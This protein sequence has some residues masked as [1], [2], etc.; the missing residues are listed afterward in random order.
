[1]WL[2]CWDTWT[3]ITRSSLSDSV[4]PEV[5]STPV[6]WYSKKAKSECS[7]GLSAVGQAELS[8]PAGV[9]EIDN[10]C[11]VV[12]VRRNTITKC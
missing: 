9:R 8:L 11:R 6:T 1:M 4:F 2:L 7:L 3:E 5:L 12:A 10:V